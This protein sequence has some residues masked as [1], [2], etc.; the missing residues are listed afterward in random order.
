MKFLNHIFVIFLI[1]V[2]TNFASAQQHII[3]NFTSDGY[4]GGTQNWQVAGDDNE[5]LYFANNYGLL[6]FDGYR[7]VVNQVKNYT[8]VRSMYIDKKENRI[9][10][11]AS[12]EFGYFY[13]DQITHKREYKSLSDKLIPEERNFTEIWRVHKWNNK[14]VFQGHYAIYIIDEKQNL[15]V[16]HQRNRIEASAVIAGKLYVV[17]REDMRIYSPKSGRITV[18]LS[19]PLRGNSIRDIVLFGK[20]ILLCT[21]NKGFF[22]YNGNTFSSFVTP[23]DDKLNSARIFSVATKGSLLAVGTVQK[24]LFLYDSKNKTIN[25]INVQSGLQNN[26]VLS[27]M[28]DKSENLWLGLDNGISFIEHHSA[29][30][31][32]LDKTESI[33]TGYAS[34]ING[35]KIYLGTNQGLFTMPITKDSL[36]YGSPTPVNGIKGQVWS[37]SKSDGLLLCGNDDGAFIVNGNNAQKI[38]G[39]DGTWV[40]RQLVKHPGYLIASDYKGL[41]VMK[42]SG[43]GYV[44]KNRLPGNNIVSNNILEDSDGSIWI[45]HWQ[46]GIYHI[47]V[48]SDLSKIVKAELFNS[49]NGLYVDHG[50]DISKIDNTVYISSV[51]GFYVYDK[52][53]KKLRNDYSINKLF[54]SYGASIKLHRTLNG[55]IWGIKSGFLAIARHPQAGKQFADYNLDNTSFQ[56][57]SNKL[58]IGLGNISDLNKHYTLFNSNDGF[59][60]IDNDYENSREV[61]KVYIRSIIGI[62]KKDTLLYSNCMKTVKNIKIAHAQNSLR[63][64][65]VMPEYRSEEG[66]RYSCF[67]ENYDKAWSAEQT[68]CYKEYTHLSKGF[69][70]F[71]VR[72]YDTING[73][74]DDQTISFEIRPAYYETVYAYIIYILILYVILYYFYLLL[75]KRNQRLMQQQKERQEKKLAELKSQHLEIEL[76]HKSNELAGSTMNLVHKNDILQDIDSEMQKLSESVRREENKRELTKKISEIRRG[77]QKSLNDDNNWDKFE[78]SFDLI[79]DN[80]MA[81]LAEHFPELKMNDRKLCAYLRMGLSSK[82]IASLMNTTTR[83][84]ETARYRLRKKLDLSQS[85]N[86]KDFIQN[87]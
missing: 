4:N 28:F 61:K 64:E 42:K 41:Y 71:H 37:L 35:N 1:V 66:I 25:N 72:A 74:T 16:I 70:K 13:Y 59:Y 23:I 68:A 30:K 5:C 45:C 39:S 54:N 84:I 55:D 19:D 22:S 62:N 85:E 67:L 43:N 46:R 79:Y 81:R 44:F 60:L 27:I 20:K 77:I 9:Y 48:N 78:E 75:Q 51:D 76:N 87:Y 56:S 32:L 29:Y 12:D 58:Q 82:E 15:Q 33:G 8:A 65:F 17:S 36:A 14:H 10:V 53:K 69:Y 7:W 47:Y 11:G 6:T 21:S 40:I 18:K 49:K 57:I 50:N 3:S 63:I 73:A 2:G 86:L 34:I 80:L 31:L 38:P 52:K 26:T 24:G 83:S